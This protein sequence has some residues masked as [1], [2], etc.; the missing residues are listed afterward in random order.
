MMKAQMTE[1]PQLSSKLQFSFDLETFF[2]KI[3]VE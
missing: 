1:N 3:L 2:F